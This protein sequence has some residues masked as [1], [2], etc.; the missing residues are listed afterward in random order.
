M[1]DILQQ[2]QQLRHQLKSLRSQFNQSH[3]QYTPPLIQNILSFISAVCS[4]ED[5]IACFWPLEGEAD[6]RPLMHE[7]HQQSYKVALPKTPVKGNPLTFYSWYPSAAMEEGRYK[8]IY[9]NTEIVEPNFILVPLM[10]FDRKGNRLGYG[11]GYYDRTLQHFTEAKSAGIAFSYQEVTTI[12]TEPFD[13]GLS[14]IITELEIIY[15]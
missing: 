14:A 13:F 11:G 2:K 4:Q 3:Y 6:L 9:P 15:T 5:V 12:P 8:T 7:L 1:I 10:G